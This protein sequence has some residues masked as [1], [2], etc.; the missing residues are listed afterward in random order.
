M[1]KKEC[2]K[3]LNSQIKILG[4]GYTSVTIVVCRLE[5]CKFTSK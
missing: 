1:R 5:K 3:C 2:D 4:R